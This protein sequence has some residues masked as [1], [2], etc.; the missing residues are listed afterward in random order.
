[1]RARAT[2]PDGLHQII[3]LADGRIVRCSSPACAITRAH[4]QDFLGEQ[5]DAT[6]QPDE[7]LRNRAR[8]FETRMNDLD[9]RAA[10]ATDPAEAQRIANEV[11][12]LDQQLREYAAQALA[13]ELGVRDVRLQTML[14]VW[15]ATELRALRAWLGADLFGHLAGRRDPNVIREF[16]RALELVGTDAVARDELRK[17]VDLS[18]RGV[19]EADLGRS[20]HELNQFLDRFGSRVSGDFVS[21]WR[22]AVQARGDPVQARA[23]LS[24]AA[25]L[26]EG[27]TPLSAAQDLSVAG[28][29]E[30][31]VPGQKTPEYRVTDAGGTSRLAEVKRLNAALTEGNI[32]T[33]LRQALSQIIPT[34]ERTGD[35]NGFVRLDATGPHSALTAEQVRAAV[36]QRMRSRR[37]DPVDP[38]RSTSGIDFVEW[39]EV[40][41][42]DSTGAQQRVLCHVVGGAVVI[43][44]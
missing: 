32:E 23:E 18:R 13:P 16:A 41:Y 40:L 24:L 26:L 6:H 2:T 22:R 8:D 14:E 27:R 34:A 10:A 29:P 19:S 35:R 43:A 7:A 44:P 11:A 31:T 3:V 25:D 20:L 17:S 1:V 38:S 30:S 15:T 12:Q 28:L 9:A 4:Y 5:R 21:R 37:P 42:T 36:E 33:N 39:V